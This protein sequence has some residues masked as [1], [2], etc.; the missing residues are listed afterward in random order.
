MLAHAMQALSLVFQRPRDPWLP[1][2][3]LLLSLFLSY[4]HTL[5]SPFPPSSPSIFSLHV[6]ADPSFRPC[7]L[8]PHDKYPANIRQSF[9]S[10]FLLLSLSLFSFS[11]RV[12]SPSSL[13]TH[14]VNAPEDG[15]SE[16]RQAPSRQT[17]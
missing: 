10:L 2:I 15:N 6:T 4:T 7:I 5:F 11:C 1:V 17:R 9:L 13:L 12:T 16:N 3:I 14:R 8:L